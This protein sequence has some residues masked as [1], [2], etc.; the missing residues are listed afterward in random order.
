MP[1]PPHSAL[2]DHPNDM[3]WGV[4]SARLFVMFVM[5]TTALASLPS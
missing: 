3:C 5:L 4:E 1:R 2:F